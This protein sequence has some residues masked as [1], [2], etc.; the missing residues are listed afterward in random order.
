MSNKDIDLIDELN[1]AT[2]PVEEFK[3]DAEIDQEIDSEDFDETP[4]LDEPVIDEPVTSPGGFKRMAKRWIKTF[5]VFQKTL[6]KPAYKKSM[7]QTGDIDKMAKY[8]EH[9]ESTK[10]DVTDIYHSH[11]GSYEVFQRF[12][13]YARAVEDLPLTQEEIDDLT[14]PLAEVIQKYS[15][16]QVGPEGQL[17]LA[18]LVIMLPRIEPVF[19]SITKLFSGATS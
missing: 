18:V 15:Y 8:K 1:E 19:P 5:N 6:L 4:E 3:P 2:K 9:A 11:E 13:R 14:E 12:E 16:M 7:L 17:L 10:K